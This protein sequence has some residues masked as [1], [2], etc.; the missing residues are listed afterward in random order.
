MR[1]LEDKV[2]IV[3]G[4]SGGIGSAICRRLA[5]DGATVVGTDLKQSPLDSLAAALAA[6]GYGILGLAA[7]VT[8]RDEAKRIVETAAETFGRID[9]LVN[10]AQSSRNV[11]LAEAGE[12][13]FGIALGTGL[14]ATF[15]FMRE[16]YPYLKES[17]GAIVN[18]GS[19]AAILGQPLNG[20]YAAA[21]EAIR[22]LSRTAVH[23]WG[24]DG[25][26][27]NVILPFAATPAMLA[28]AKK[29]PGLYDKSLE[30]VALRRAG[31]PL[32]DIAPV[33]SWL[34]SD[35]AGYVTGQTIAVDGGQIVIP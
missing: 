17:R 27:I 34:L 22:G 33:V 19:G 10:N 32:G 13:D 16:C 6:D 29:H 20:P 23:E 4:A 25:I 31:D 1:R 7:D 28:W 15:L 3:T 35:E 30:A 9:G 5:A 11:P 21:K 8:K 2:V 14:W 12:E 26:R 24:P 18:F